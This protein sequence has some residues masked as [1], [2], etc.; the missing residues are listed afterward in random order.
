MTISLTE[1][2]VSCS[3][4]K[5]LWLQMIRIISVAMRNFIL[6]SRLVKDFQ[7][8]S[9]LQRKLHTTTHYDRQE[10]TE[11]PDGSFQ[12]TV[13]TRSS[14]AA[15]A[16]TLQCWAV[17]FISFQWRL[18]QFKRAITRQCIFFI[19]YSIILS[20][21]RRTYTIEI[22]KYYLEVIP[23]IQSYFRNKYNIL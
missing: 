7:I 4:H 16:A 23:I 20:E 6:L 1:A 8:K 21:R 18:R 2:S 3:Q 19:N 15:Q 12:S 9:A 14:P 13:N 22:I 10:N 17:T 11:P 5:Y